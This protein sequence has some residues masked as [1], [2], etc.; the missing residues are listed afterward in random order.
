VQ[1]DWY[2]QLVRGWFKFLWTEK[3]K[4]HVDVYWVVEVVLDRE[5]RRCLEMRKSIEGLEVEEISIEI[6]M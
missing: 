3:F 1:G 2:R 5:S 4:K 6:E